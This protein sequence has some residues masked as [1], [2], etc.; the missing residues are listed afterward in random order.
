MRSTQLPPGQSRHL[1]RLLHGHDDGL[2]CRHTNHLDFTCMYKFHLF[3]TACRLSDKVAFWPSDAQCAGLSSRVQCRWTL[4][5]RVANAWQISNA[6]CATN[7]SGVHTNELYHVCV[8]SDSRV[9]TSASVNKH[10]AWAAQWSPLM[11]ITEVMREPQQ[12]CTDRDTHLHRVLRPRP[13]R[14]ARAAGTRGRPPH[15]LSPGPTAQA[16][17]PWQGS[18]AL[19]SK[20]TS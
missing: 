16:T 3:I 18:L 13:Q 17:P 9:I 10:H 15:T 2:D 7:T 1:L 6:R 19:R 20:F 8:C 11:L 12:V 5:K 4:D 14:R